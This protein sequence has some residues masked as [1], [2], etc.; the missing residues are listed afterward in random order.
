VSD[1]AFPTGTVTFLFSD[2]E[3]STALVRRVGNETFA[4]IRVEHRRLLRAAF[5]AH[6]GIEID[7]AGDGF[8]VA[9]DSAREGVEAAIEGQRALAEFSWP[10]GAVVRVRMG[11]HTAE[12][13]LGADGY[14]GVGVHRAARICDAGRGG[15]ILV[16]NATAGIVEDAELPGVGIVDLGEHR[17]KG[18]LV[19]QRLFQLS[20]PGLQPTFGAPRTADA[21]ARQTPG[22]GT[23][24]LADLTNWRNLIQAVGDDA[25]AA[26]LADYHTLATALV[27]EH[28]GTILELIGDTIV[29]VFRSASDAVRAA[30][31]LRAAVHGTN[32]PTGCDVSVSIVLH[33]GRWSGDP[34]QPRAGTAISRLFDLHRTGAGGRTLVSASTAALVEG[35]RDIPSL[36]GLGEQVVPDLDAPVHLYELVD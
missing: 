24:L 14:V 5:S 9:F 21:E 15:Q 7:T 13:H 34:R 31:A 26:L 32:W 22:A 6:G 10:E 2:I 27:G 36:R 4:A 25:S 17:L 29:A 18:L 23:F 19:E 16:S 33:S 35:D 11:L 8:F 20:A 28:E 12:P 3:D 30:A 1:A